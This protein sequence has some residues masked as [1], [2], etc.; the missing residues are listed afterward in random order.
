MSDGKYAKWFIFGGLICRKNDIR[1]EC[2]AKHYPPEYEKRNT[3]NEQDVKQKERIGIW[4]EQC[5]QLNV[6]NCIG[7]TQNHENTYKCIQCGLTKIL[8]FGA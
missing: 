2:K 8:K 4:C 3:F 5:Q 6:H 7:R 1:K